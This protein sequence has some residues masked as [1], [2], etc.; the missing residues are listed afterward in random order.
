[1]N[2]LQFTGQDYFTDKDIGSIV[3][4]LPN[5]ALGSAEVG[6]W[7]RTL[8]KVGDAWVQADRGARPSQAVFLPGDDRLAYLAAEPANDARFI[9]TFAHS[10]EHAGGYS[11]DEARRVAG[12]LLPDILR[13]DP[14]CAASYPNNGR[15]LT[16]DVSDHFLAILTNGKVTTDKVGPHTDLLAAFPYLG[17]PHTIRS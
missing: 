1:L 2:N 10:L 3:L 9:A 16:D 5:A 4:E 7:A 14:R 13:F 17:S 12:T 6:L 8:A 11:P 15:A